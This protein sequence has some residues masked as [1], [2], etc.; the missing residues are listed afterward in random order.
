MPREFTG[1][2]IREIRTELG[3]SQ[4]R[5]GEEFG[6]FRPVDQTTVWRWEANKCRPRLRHR[7]RLEEL[8]LIVERKRRRIPREQN[9]RKK[10]LPVVLNISYT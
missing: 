8:W 9:P 3:L 10:D 7:K 4:T 5:F 2:E 6:P 1:S